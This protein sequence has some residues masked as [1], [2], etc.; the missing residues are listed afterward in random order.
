MTLAPGSQR[1]GV[2]LP[3]A[4]KAL[5]ALD[6]ALFAI[7]FAVTRVRQPFSDMLA[8]LGAYLR[9][10]QTGDL[11]T[12]LLAF[13]NEH[14][15]VW[16]RL[17]TIVDATGFH[18]SGLPFVVAS[19]VALV[20]AAVLVT[21]EM[22][23]GAQP[24]LPWLF[25]MLFLTA[26]NAIDCGVPINCVYPLTLVFVILSC[27]LFD[28]EA[29]A[30]R[31]T[32][33]R[34][35]AAIGCAAAAGFANAVG[36]LAWPVLLWLAWRGEARAQWLALI[37]I[38]GAAYCAAYLH[39]MPAVIGSPQGTEAASFTLVCGYL[40]AYLGLPLSRMASFPL[41]GRL[42]GLAML[43]FGIY[44]V[45]R[46]GFLN[47]ELTRAQRIATALVLFSLGGAA[48]AAVGRSKLAD[49]IDVPVRY[50]VLVA[51]LH[52]GLLALA[53][54]WAS[55]HARA[56]LAGAVGLAAVLVVVQVVGGIAAMRAVGR[57]AAIV[58]RY[59][60][61]ERDPQMA[62]ILYPDLQDADRVVAALRRE[63]LFAD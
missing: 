3:G 26:A 2:S 47:R 22:A 19:T 20:V 34:R 40:L 4:L 23:R 63:G 46:V 14:R 16:I 56:A 13:H 43:A 51:P 54:P 59:Y 38:V 18:C 62:K 53:L 6:V 1:R 29:E 58:A 60:A 17:L 45:I 25:P 57:M 33:V 9:F 35:S 55:R 41:P 27:T 32:T 49:G 8:W 37:G 15:L 21:R 31:G 39:G 44:A 50:A 10:R 61:G 7:V 48:M 52:A 24:A 36:L 5:A 42:L 12:Y 30:S 11:F 28:G